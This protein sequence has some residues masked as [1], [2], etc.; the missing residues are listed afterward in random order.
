MDGHDALKYG[1]ADHLAEEGGADELAL[2][3]AREVAQV[4]GLAGWLAG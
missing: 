2:R 4:G 3:V 1:L